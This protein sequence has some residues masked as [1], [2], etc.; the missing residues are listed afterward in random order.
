MAIEK[1]VQLQPTAQIFG[2]KIVQRVRFTSIAQALQAFK[3]M[4]FDDRPL[5]Q[6]DHLTEE[7]RCAAL[8][9]KLSEGGKMGDLSLPAQGFSKAVVGARII[10]IMKNDNAEM[11]SDAGRAVT[12]FNS[13][14]WKTMVPIV[15][16]SCLIEY[17][18][19]DKKF[20]DSIKANLGRSYKECRGGGEEVSWE[21]HHTWTTGWSAIEKGKLDP[22]E[23][24][25]G[26]DLTMDAYQMVQDHC[27][28]EA[29]R[30]KAHEQDRRNKD[31]GNPVH[32]IPI[33]S[34]LNFGILIE[35]PG[36]KS[37][38]S[39]LFSHPKRIG[40]GVGAQEGIEPQFGGEARS[41]LC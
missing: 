7:D 2:E 14:I 4:M 18:E 39:R 41:V 28:G 1:G 30:K 27:T 37:D 32:W 29:E 11:L 3:A 35:E 24:V 16:G 34:D 15:A 25:I 8:N 36:C 26:G 22:K 40:V 33:M 19:Q 9:F 6:M 17:Y 5:L 38:T 20:A 13:T 31:Y 23:D 10:M 21:N 12:G